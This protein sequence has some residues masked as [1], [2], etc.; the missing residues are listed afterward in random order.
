MTPEEHAKDLYWKY[1]EFDGLS[2]TEIKK[3]CDIAIDVLVKEAEGDM[4]DFWKEVKSL[5][6]R[7]GL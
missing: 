5:V 7:R 2:S 1:S 6:N 3:C 4:K